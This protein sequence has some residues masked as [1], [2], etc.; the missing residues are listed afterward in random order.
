MNTLPIESLDLAEDHLAS[1][2]VALKAARGALGEHWIAASHLAEAF[3][4]LYHARMGLAAE[5]RGRERLGE[6][7]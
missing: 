4:D 1:A 2:T 5:K 3:K 7:A 6:T